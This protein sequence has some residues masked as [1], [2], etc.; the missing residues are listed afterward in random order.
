[1]FGGET[2]ER[3]VSVMSGTNV[4]LK[5]EKSDIYQPEPYFL[6]INGDIW[7][8]SL[9]YALSHTVEEIL[10]DCVH[11]SRDA[12]RMRPYVY[13]IR[14]QLGLDQSYDPT[15][16]LPVRM[17]FEDF[18]DETQKS[19]AFTF[20][21]L[22][23]GAGEDGRIQTQLEERGILYN[24]SDAEGAEL[25]MDK[26]RTGLAIQE[27]GFSDIYTAPKEL[28]TLSE[29]KDFDTEWNR[30]T[31]EF[32]CKSLIIKPIGDG[33]SAGI[34][35][36]NNPQDLKNYTAFITNKS[37]IIPENSFDG[38]S[39]PI[40]LSP[41]SESD[42]EYLLEA[43]IETDKICIDNS[44]LVREAGT[45]WIELTVG[46]LEK[47][48]QYH[49]LTPSITVASGEVLSLEEKFQG[50]TGINFTPPPKEIISDNLITK[51][52]SDIEQIAETLGIK[53]Y[54]RIDVFVNT[55]SN[56]TIVIE[57]NSLPGL[58][59]STVIYHQGLAEDESMPP[60]AFLEH[61][62][63]NTGFGS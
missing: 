9:P 26:H 1:M 37:K 12:K 52:K 23:G 5:L 49:S 35:R 41:N 22:H 18:L 19:G 34:V 57:A 36:L 62:I 40:E 11:A 46:V 38:Q 48:G 8:I 14:E 44:K 42:K 55:I 33:C 45:G 32:K 63:S 25:C 10:S 21:G 53:N 54:A 59:P 27:K 28:I 24:G 58:T 51:I 17:S 60:T 61:I 13:K 43:F 56:H 47:E 39:D 29:L 2:A 4:W 6:D 30:L 16:D 50:G 20:L 3:Q 7:H 15:Q 31:S